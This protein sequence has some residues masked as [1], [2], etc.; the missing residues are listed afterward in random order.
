MEPFSDATSVS[1]AWRDIAE[2]RPPLLEKLREQ[3][4]LH[5]DLSNNALNDLSCLSMCPRL[6]SLVL[7]GKAPSEKWSRRRRAQ[8]TC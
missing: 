3:G 5:L 2:L 7:D 1:L 4:T 6:Q 8:E